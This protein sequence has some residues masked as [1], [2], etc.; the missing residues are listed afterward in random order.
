MEDYLWD[1]AENDEARVQELIDGA[2][3]TRP[4]ALVLNARGIAPEQIQDFLNPS[5]SNIGDPYLLP[6][7]RDASARLWQAIQKNQRIL[8]HGDYD[9]DGITASAL[10]AWVLRRN[11]AQVECYL[12]HRIDDGYGLTAESIAKTYRKRRRMEAAQGLTPAPARL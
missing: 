8:I 12:P 4:I 7:T 3:V 11:G 2:G 6:G 1:L 5:L 10:V 9:T